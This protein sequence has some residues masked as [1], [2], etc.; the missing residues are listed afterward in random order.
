MILPVLRFDFL[1]H[2]LL[3]DNVW[4]AQMAGC[5]KIL[6]YNGRDPALRRTTRGEAMHYQHGG[7]RYEIPHM[8]S[9]DEYPFACAV[10][11]G[12]RSW[13]GHIPPAQNSAQGGMISAFIQRHGLVAGA[14][15]RVEVVNHRNGRVTSRCLPACHGCP[16]PC[17]Y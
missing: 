10:E 11:G 13:V 5:P 3:A 12:G 8:D 9:R 4:Q 16:A 15:F 6:T 17:P 1:Q 14:R 2:Q 7:A